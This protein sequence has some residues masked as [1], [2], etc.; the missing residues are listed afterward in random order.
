MEHYQQIRVILEILEQGRRFLVTSHARPD[1]DAVGSMLAC[2]AMLQQLGKQADIVSNDRVPLI[3][4]CL[5][6][7]SQVRCISQMEGDYDAVI[8]LECDGLERTG[9]A[10]LEG[11][12]IINIDHHATGH[13]F[14]DVNWIDRKACAVAE[15]VY[16]LALAA[17]ARITPDIATCIYAAVL[18]DTGSFCYG[19]T[20]EHTFELARELVL[21]GANPK[22]IAQDIYFCN[23]TSKIL[24]LGSALSN[25][26]R[27]GRIAWMWVT[28]NDMVRANAAEED[29]EGIVNYGISIAGVEVAAFLRELPD[30]RVRVSL[31][32][33]GQI[34]V[35]Q[36][37]EHFGGG[38]HK[39]AS[40]CTLPGPL[41]AAADRIL[42]LLRNET[43]RNVHDVA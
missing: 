6:G 14:G 30:H 17:G 12:R 31:R 21:H 3:Y 15:M 18:T 9:I 36:A 35:A 27:E 7:A 34:D 41:H 5:P 1:G 39:N 25:L 28:H 42:A 37:A 38:G 33:K 20:D 11:Q 10:G 23:P 22:A 13:D 29:C 24:L 19:N 40:G 43:V 26:K 2:G 16:E 32:S 4:T 8:V